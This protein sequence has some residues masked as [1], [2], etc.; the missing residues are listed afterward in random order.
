MR[1][2]TQYWLLV[3]KH[4][5]VDSE[6]QYEECGACLRPSSVDDAEWGPYVI[7]QLPSGV[8]SAINTGGCLELSGHA[9]CGAQYQ[10]GLL[11]RHEACA[12]NCHDG[13]QYNQC[14][15]DADAVCADYPSSPS[16][17]T[18]PLPFATRSTARP[19]FSVVAS[20]AW[21]PWSAKAGTR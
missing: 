5:E 18:P 15:S 6:R 2:E 16:C 12:D 10:A 13:E 9:D 19:P 4:Q 1:Q 17:I 20:A 11:C 3:A 7:T 8:A 14:K 21:P